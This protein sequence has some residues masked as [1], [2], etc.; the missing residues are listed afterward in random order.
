MNTMTTEQC[1]YTYSGRN[2]GRK[3][4]V[5]QRPERD[6]CKGPADDADETHDDTCKMNFDSASKTRPMVHHP[7]HRG[8]VTSKGAER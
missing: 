3:G 1:S 4:Q 6:H 8:P 7:Y 5:C 2:G